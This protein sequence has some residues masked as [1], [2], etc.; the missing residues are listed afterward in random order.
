MM[1]ENVYLKKKI[2][3]KKKKQRTLKNVFFN[4]PILLNI[5]AS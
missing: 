4:A 5:E 3:Q 1:S 2:I